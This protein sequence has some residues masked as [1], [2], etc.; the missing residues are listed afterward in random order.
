M[1]S[2][3]LIIPLILIISGFLSKKKHNILSKILFTIGFSSYITLFAIISC[4]ISIFS[5][6]AVIAGFTILAAITLLIFTLSIIWK[7]K[8]PIMIVSII[9]FIILLIPI[10]TIIGQDIYEKNLPTLT[11]PDVLSEYL[12]D[13]KKLAKINTDFKIDS[14]FPKL[15]GATALFPI[16]IS[17][18]NEIYPTENVTKKLDEHA[19][20]EITKGDLSKY[21]SEN[22]LK[23]FP[24]CSTVWNEELVDC[25]KTK[26]AYRKIVDGEA[27]II[28]VAGPSKEQEEYAKEKGVELIY[29]PIG[30][31]A[32]VF[33]V[34]SKNP[35]E[36]LS[37]EQIQSIY[38]SQT[39]NW[40]ALGIKKLGEIKAF[41]RAEGSGSQTALQKLM[42]EKELMIPPQEDVIDL[43]GGIIDRTADYKNF[44]N[45]IGFSFRFYSTEM[46]KNNQIRLLSLNGI[47]PTLENI[48]NGTYPIT[49]EFYAVSRKDGT[50]NTKRIIEWLSTKDAQ[51]IIEQVGYTP[52]TK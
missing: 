42:A 31:E 18:A 1:L 27:D 21:T 6:L 17:I 52:L 19:C 48:E 12:P 22:F 44:K 7:F 45:A 29:T 15:D 16:Y 20:Y 36:D 32:F 11:E 49:S 13:S 41:Q 51:K 40:K 39:T 47:A 34:N 30:K 14:E 33:F 37:V 46:V 9:F 28:F 43:M 25:S 10:G 35:I 50:E 26:E 3:I 2:L 24:E 8:K 38:S 4:I 5:N 23:K